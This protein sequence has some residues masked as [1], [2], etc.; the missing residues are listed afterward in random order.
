MSSIMNDCRDLVD[1]ANE[2]HQL[3]NIDDDELGGIYG[4]EKHTKA[5]KIQ[6]K[7]VSRRCIDTV[8]GIQGA[9]RKSEKRDFAA[10]MYF[11]LSAKTIMDA[12]VY[13][14]DLANEVKGYNQ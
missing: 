12:H 7:E 3:V 10:K 1:M 14:S 8:I 6:M 5:L 2:G 13:A 4:L 11:L 9:K